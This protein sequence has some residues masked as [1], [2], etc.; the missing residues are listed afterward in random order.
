M[1]GMRKND[2]PYDRTETRTQALVS[3]ELEVYPSAHPV[4]SVGYLW[5]APCYLGFV[6]AHPKIFWCVVPCAR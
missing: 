6:L 5:T 2:T 3:K 1:Q 4:A